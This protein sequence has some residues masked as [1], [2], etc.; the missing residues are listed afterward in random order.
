MPTTRPRHTITETPNVKDALDQLRD[1]LPKGEKIDY[2][3]LIVLGARAKARRLSAEE[4]E[5]RA[6][7]ERLAEM[8][9]MG[10]FPWKTDMKA[11]EEVKNLELIPKYE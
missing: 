4:A 7:R 5:D 1:K 11:A 2:A 3:E 8:I 6:A 10:S 9:R